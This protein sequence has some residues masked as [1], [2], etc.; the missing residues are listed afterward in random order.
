MM[1]ERK[2]LIRPHCILPLCV[3][4]I[5]NLISSCTTCTRRRFD[6]SAPSLTQT[7]LRYA[8]CT[9]RFANFEGAEPPRWLPTMVWCI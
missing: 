5:D 9:A 7:G 2:G 4:A 8:L 3:V 1:K 6:V